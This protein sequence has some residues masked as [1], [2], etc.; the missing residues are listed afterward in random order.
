MGYLSGF[1]ARAQVAVYALL[2]STGRMNTDA[3]QLISAG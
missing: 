1:A 2:L 3:L